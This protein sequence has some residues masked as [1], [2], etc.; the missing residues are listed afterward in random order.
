[1]L[2]PVGSSF[3]LTQ[4]ST[5]LCT[6]IVEALNFQVLYEPFDRPEFDYTRLREVKVSATGEKRMLGEN[7]TGKPYQIVY[8]CSDQQAVPLIPNTETVFDQVKKRFKIRRYTITGA[9]NFS[10]EIDDLQIVATDH[11]KLLAEFQ[12]YQARVSGDIGYND[13]YAYRV[14]NFDLSGGPNL[15]QT[16]ITMAGTALDVTET[17]MLITSMSAETTLSIPTSDPSVQEFYKTFSLTIEN[18]IIEALR[19]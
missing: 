11:L 5:V 6:M 19:A 2:N 17:N 9:V 13:L 10:E 8:G 1:M 7:L 3:A 16:G 15:T 12:G 4:S 18:R 14:W